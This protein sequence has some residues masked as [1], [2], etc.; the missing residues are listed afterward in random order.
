VSAE[1]PRDGLRIAVAIH[2]VAPATIEECAELREML[3]Q[4]GIDRATLLAIP[5]PGGRPFDQASPEML[6]WLLERMAAGDTVA[7]HGCRHFQTRS[8]WP[9]RQFV[10]RA[11]GGRAAEFVGLDPEETVRAVAAGREVMRRA[12][13]EPRGFVA[14]AYA[15]TRSLRRELDRGFEWWASLWRVHRRA[16]PARP[17]TSPAFGLGTSTWLKRVTSPSLFEAASL[18]ARSLLR[19]DLHPADLDL[20]GHRRVI[21]LV[22]R[23]AG[24]RRSVTYDALA[25]DGG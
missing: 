4:C 15:Y 10:A 16:S 7:Q 22:L 6:G 12:G 24:S 21:D 20:A 1:P 23:R 18:T 8:G 2:D 17:I 25:A 5:F 3:L 19:F 9:G 13:L 11:Q 14:P